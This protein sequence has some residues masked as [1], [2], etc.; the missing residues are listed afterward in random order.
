MWCLNVGSNTR[1]LV[2]CK[3]IYKYSEINK[4]GKKSNGTKKIKKSEKI[5][6]CFVS[7]GI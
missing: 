3:T 2:Y 5:K 6:Y 7:I 4:N 1:L